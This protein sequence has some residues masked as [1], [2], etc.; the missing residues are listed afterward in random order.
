MDV[1]QVKLCKVV[2]DWEAWRSKSDAKCREG[3]GEVRKFSWHLLDY[4]TQY[5]QTSLWL[6]CLSWVELHWYDRSTVVLC[7]IKRQIKRQ[8]GKPS[9]TNSAVFRC[10]SISWTGCDGQS[11]TTNFSDY[12]LQITDYNLT[13]LQPYCKVITTLQ[14]YNFTTLQLYNLTT[15]GTAGI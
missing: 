6:C 3:E 8:L 15:C 5:V 13:T 14:P 12:R 1:Q 7:C 9:N 4:K 10:A 11:L 2:W